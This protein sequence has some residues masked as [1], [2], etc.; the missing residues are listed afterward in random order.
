MD[1]LRR[2]TDYSLRMM[3]N[4]AHNFNGKFISAR[5]LAEEGSLSYQLGCKLLQRLHKAN[6]VK[7]S[8]GPHGGFCLSRE[9]SKI[10]LLEVIRSVQGP[11]SLN[12]CLLN[13]NSYP[14][15]PN[16]ATSRKLAKLQE[17]IDDYLHSITLADLLPSKGDL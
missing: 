3:V 6:L 7:S 8:M 12:R 11:V 17:Y 10:S 13:V 16:C 15:Q 4:I 2:N 1:V 14:R 5:Q 9:S